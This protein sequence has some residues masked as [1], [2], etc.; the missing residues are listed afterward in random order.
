M[1][2]YSLSTTGTSPSTPIRPTPSWPGDKPESRTCRSNQ[3]LPCCTANFQGSW[4]VVGTADSCRRIPRK[5]RIRAV[6]CSRDG[7]RCSA[8][9]RATEA[10]A[11]SA[12][13]HHP[14]VSCYVRLRLTLYPEL[15]DGPFIRYSSDPTFLLSLSGTTIE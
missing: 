6:F 7:F 8:R 14:M 15:V 13:D 4:A 12:Q 11:Y 1:P 2:I 3:R 9:L 5:H 10:I